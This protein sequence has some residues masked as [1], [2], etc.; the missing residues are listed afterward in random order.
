MKKV[1]PPRG[2]QGTIIHN[3]QDCI[4][5]GD[6]SDKL[7][8]LPSSAC[9]CSVIQRVGKKPNTRSILKECSMMKCGSGH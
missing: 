4:M 2:A 7:V 1:K 5:G 3:L 6:A 8:C 9:R